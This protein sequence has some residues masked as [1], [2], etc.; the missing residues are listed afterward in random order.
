MKVSCAR[1]SLRASSPAVRVPEEKDVISL[2]GTASDVASFVKMS[3]SLD[4]AYALR[5]KIALRSTEGMSL[6]VNKGGTSQIIDLGAYEITNG[7]II[8][9]ID[10]IFAN[11]LDEAITFT[12]MKNG[13]EIGK[14][15]TASVNAYLYRASIGSDESLSTLAKALY[16]YG[17]VAKTYSK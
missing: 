14:T 16:A 13:V 3:L 8:V 12:L 5:L 4:G 7:I 2:T 11:E 6:K 17:E 1:S 10:D 15:L 9:T